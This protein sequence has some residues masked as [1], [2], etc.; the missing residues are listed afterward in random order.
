MKY[1]LGIVLPFEQEASGSLR[2][3]PALYVTE[4]CTGKRWQRRIE[5][6]I[7]SLVGWSSVDWGQSN[8]KAGRQEIVVL[9]GG[10]FLASQSA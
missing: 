6:G 1:R 8:R 2:N 5:K 7:G 3:R 10:P 9:I 4:H